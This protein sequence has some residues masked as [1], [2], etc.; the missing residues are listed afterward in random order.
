MGLKSRVAVAVSLV[1]AA[2]AINAFAT[3]FDSHP[4][5]FDVLV[6]LPILVFALGTVFRPE[7]I[8]WLSEKNREGIENSDPDLRR[9]M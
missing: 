2:A 7:W 1:L 8:D 4:L 5:A 6:D 9:W 3:R